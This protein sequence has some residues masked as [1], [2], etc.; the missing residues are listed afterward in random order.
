MT[1]LMWLPIGAAGLALAWWLGPKLM[2]TPDE[3]ARDEPTSDVDPDSVG[4]GVADANRLGGFLG[5][6]IPDLAP[7]DA[8]DEVG[9]E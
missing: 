8:G 3:V 5:S 4:L 1:P 6:A 7:P 2:T 9:E